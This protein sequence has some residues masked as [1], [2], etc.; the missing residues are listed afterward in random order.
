MHKQRFIAILRSHLRYLAPA[1]ELTPDTSLRE[2]GLDSMMAVALLLDL[3]NEFGVTLP[4]SSLNPETFAS[5]NH[6]WAEVEKA[7]SL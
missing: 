3:E 4:D 6:L 5:A 7:A 2:L 1:E